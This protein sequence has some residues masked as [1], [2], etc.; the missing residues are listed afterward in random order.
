MHQYLSGSSL[1]AFFFLLVLL[2]CTGLE[3]GAQVD[4]PKRRIS[5][6]PVPAFGYSPE[7][8]AYVGVVGLFT[9]RPADTLSRSSNAELEFNA[10][11]N[12]N[13]AIH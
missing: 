11:M 9:L 5:V 7:T 2:F 8:K 1:Q 13:K 3:I 12:R 10:T 6:L 4:L